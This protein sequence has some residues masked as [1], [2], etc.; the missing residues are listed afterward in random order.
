MIWGII[1]MKKLLLSCLPLM[2]LLGGCK[3]KRLRLAPLNNNTAHFKQKNNQVTIYSRVL[4]RK[5]KQA[6]FAGRT[7]KLSSSIQ[8]VQLTIKNKSTVPFYFD[9]V[10]SSLPLIN[11]YILIKSLQKN[12]V[13]TPLLTFTLG[14]FPLTYFSFVTTWTLVL[15][16]PLALKPAAYIIPPLFWFLAFFPSYYAYSVTAHNNE[17]VEYNVGN[18]ILSKAMIQPEE[19]L[20]GVIFPTKRDLHKGLTI[21][22]QNVINNKKLFFPISAPFSHQK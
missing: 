13:S 10:H 4:N 11:P 22:L 17:V 14:L 20:N 16:P 9:P 1:K 18:N 19:L 15:L 5:E 12:T 6:L 21:Q 2:I 7:P 3:H 8:P